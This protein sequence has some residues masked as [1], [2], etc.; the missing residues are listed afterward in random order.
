MSSHSAAQ[1]ILHS[2][3]LLHH[4]PEDDDRS[5]VTFWLPKSQHRREDMARAFE[6]IAEIFRTAPPSGLD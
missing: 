1:L 5:A 2:S 3:P 6:R 4:P